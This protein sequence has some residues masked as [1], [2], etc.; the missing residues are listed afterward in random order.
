MN[1]ICL[2]FPRK[3]MFTWLNKKCLL[4][5]RQFRVELSYTDESVQTN[6]QL[7][8]RNIESYE[9]NFSLLWHLV[10][11]WNCYIE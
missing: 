9:R 1:Y 11:V 2:G 6:K 7:R 4:G 5:H 10:R 8:Q 3:K